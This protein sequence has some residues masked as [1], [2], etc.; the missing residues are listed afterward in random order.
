LEIKKKLN[1]GAPFFF[2]CVGEAQWMLEH[3]KFVMRT[4]WGKTGVIMSCG[5]KQG[6]VTQ[7]RCVNVGSVSHT[8]T[9]QASPF[10]FFYDKTN[11]LRLR[12]EYDIWQSDVNAAQVK[13][14]AE[15]GRD[16][17]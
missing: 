12:R 5:Q 7:Q 9:I 14:Y 8:G 10:F 4:C 1:T 17:C 13:L 2:V 6:F 15:R 16:N 11:L 3:V